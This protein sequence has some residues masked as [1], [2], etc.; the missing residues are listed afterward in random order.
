M[1]QFAFNIG[2]NVTMLTSESHVNLDQLDTPVSNEQV[3][4]KK[5]NIIWATLN[6]THWSNI[7]LFEKE[8]KKCRLAFFFLLVCGFSSWTASRLNL[9]MGKKNHIV[10]I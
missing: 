7:S 1:I 10:Y 4:K 3:K 5:L 9:E 8:I 2:Q 6:L